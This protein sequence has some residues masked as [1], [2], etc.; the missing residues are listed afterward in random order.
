MN[1]AL[2]VLFL[3]GLSTVGALAGAHAAGTDNALL[4]A[5][6]G[7][8]D[9]YKISFVDASTAAVTHATAGTYT[10]DVRDDSAI[11]NLHLVGPGVDK[12]TTIPGTGQTSWTVTLQN[13]YY[14]FYCDPHIASMH[15]A[16]TVGSGRLPLTAAVATG[17]DLDIKD[18][19]QLSPSKLTEGT[20]TITV[21]D[22]SA[23]DNFRLT[24]PGV[25]RATGLAFRGTA[26]WK[27]SLAAG[28][29][30]FRSDSHRTRRHT[31]R[32]SGVPSWG[33]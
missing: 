14:R 7:T 1:R 12:A 23:K 5:T 19:F 2:V 29:Y 9:A 22:R 27:V 24:G 25:N 17:G 10:I 26:R 32:V 3:A 20:Y 8:N 13:G 6:V 33:P 16:F 31:F 18:A 21:H 11:H 15:G 30:T 28:T 4:S